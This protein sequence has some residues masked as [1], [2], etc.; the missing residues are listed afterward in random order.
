MGPVLPSPELIVLTNRNIEQIQRIAAN[1]LHR[2]EVKGPKLHGAVKLYHQ[3]NPATV[4]LQMK[5][6]DEQPPS[7]GNFQSPGGGVPP[8]EPVTCVRSTRG[9]VHN[10]HS[11][12]VI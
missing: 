3:A 1:H 6:L 2:S 11:F 9:E 8:A 7:S 4:I 12:A 10:Y 5:I